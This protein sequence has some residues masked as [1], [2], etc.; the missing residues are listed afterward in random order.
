MLDKPTV[1]NISKTIANISNRYSLDKFRY[2]NETKDIQTKNDGS[3]VTV[4]DKEIQENL[5]EAL[6]KVIPNAKFLVEE[7]PENH[8][9]CY[10]QHEQLEEASQNGPVFIIDPIDGT[11]N[12]I[13]GGYDFRT[14]VA[15]YHNKT[16]IASWIHSPTENRTI[17]ALADEGAWVEQTNTKLSLKPNKHDKK[18]TIETS[19]KISGFFEKDYQLSKRYSKS[20]SFESLAFQDTSG[21]VFHGKMKSWDFLPGILVFKEA[22]GK[23]Y[24]DFN[25]DASQPQTLVF[26]E[27]KEILQE[28]TGLVKEN[29]VDR[30]KEKVESV[31]TQKVPEH[32]K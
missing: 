22:G 15:L 28:L 12:F 5:V 2:L 26:A 19:S 27:D 17:C 8:D 11:G 16:T 30:G 23:V 1:R 18:K 29:Q 7:V 3:Q 4:A 25:L 21:A 24:K 32:E 6:S 31:P 14:S 13:R 9:D 10:I 20:A